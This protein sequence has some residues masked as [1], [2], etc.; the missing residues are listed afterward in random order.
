MRARREAAEKGEEPADLS[1]ETI[2]VAT[3]FSMHAAHATDMA[4]DYAK[5]LGVEQPP[6]DRDAEQWTFPFWE[7]NDIPWQQ[8]HRKWGHLGEVDPQG[9]KRYL[10]HLLALDD[11]LGR[12]LDAID[13]T[14][15]K[16]NTVVVFVSDNGGTINTYANNGPLN[17]WKFMFGEGGLRIPMIIAAPGRLP[18]G[19]Q[20][21]GMT[22][23]MDVV[24]TVLDLVYTDLPDNLEDLQNDPHT[25]G[26]LI[27]VK[28]DNAA[29]LEGLKDA[30]A[31]E[32]VVAS[33]S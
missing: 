29:A 30:A 7:P 32:E 9:R 12:L 13:K 31:Y 17:G 25:A 11:N 10:S 16:D 1:I 23:A 27:K 19:Q 15:E 24:P 6:W 26:W 20:L 4:I 22:S 5:K 14:G 8:W 21:A 33:E 3:D 28:V 2:L 18:G